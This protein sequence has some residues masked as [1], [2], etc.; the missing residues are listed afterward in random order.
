VTVVQTCALPIGKQ[1]YDG[2]SA[3]A[4]CF[5]GFFANVDAS[6]VVDATGAGAT[7]HTAWAIYEN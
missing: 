3:D 4:K 7:T 6:M 2:I 1:V 5:G